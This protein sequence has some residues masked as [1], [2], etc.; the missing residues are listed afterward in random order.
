[1]GLKNLLKIDT[2]FPRAVLKKMIHKDITEKP[3]KTSKT[4]KIIQYFRK[5]GPFWNLPRVAVSKTTFC[6]KSISV[7]VIS[8]RFLQKKLFSVGL[9]QVK[10]ECLKEAKNKNFV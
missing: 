10:L 8:R 1:M 2:N 6:K 3:C 9:T 7:F 5:I 4:S